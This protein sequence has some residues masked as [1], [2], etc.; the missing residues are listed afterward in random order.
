MAV[1][2][3]VDT[4]WNPAGF[5][6]Q[7]YTGDQTADSVSKGMENIKKCA[8]KKL[9]KNQPLLILIDITELGR[10]DS[11]SHSAGIKGIKSM[12]FERAAVYGPLQAQVLV[13]TLVLVAGKKNRMRAF[14]DRSDAVKWLLGRSGG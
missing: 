8:A 1:K 2:P 13:N 4:F 12:D 7:K 5:V 3:Q 14:S 9:E 6:Q 11:A 10:T